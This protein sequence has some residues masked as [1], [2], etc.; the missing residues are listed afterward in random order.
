MAEA[1]VSSRE[2]RWSLKGM[3]ALV[4]GGTRGIG[5][6]IVEELAGFGA[7]VH[8]CSRTETELDECIK[9]WERKGFRVTGSVCDVSC[10]TQRDELI[11]KVS[12]TF[13]GKL[14]ILVNNAATVVSKDSTEV[15]AEDMAN[16]L[17]TNVEASYHLC[18]LA[19]P[20]LKASGN[21]S[22]VFISSVAAVLAL[23]TLTF[24]GASK[25]ALNQLTR[26]LACEWGNDKIR[27]NA[28]APWII[29]TPLLDASLARTGSEQRAGM[30]RI[31]SQTPISRVGEPTEISSLVAFLCLPTASY[32]T[33]QVVSVDGG[34]TANGG[35]TASGF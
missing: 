32:I 18:Q 26:S 7:A 35:Y 24:Y 29:K 1:E 2:S 19:H 5:F 10:Q 16:T 21:G 11:E 30:I 4:T 23:P 20:L 25:G 27:V 22:I 28:V 14:N 34:Y 15:T 13:Q 3:T 33:G 17:G 8:T 9:E 31:L 12:S 6:A